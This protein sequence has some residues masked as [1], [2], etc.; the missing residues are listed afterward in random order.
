MPVCQCCPNFVSPGI[1]RCENCATPVGKLAECP[2]CYREILKDVSK[3]RHCGYYISDDGR[4]ASEYK[5]SDRD[6]FYLNDEESADSDELEF[7][8][9]QDAQEDF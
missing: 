2:N 6:S 9:E 7:G 8:Y 3:C 5:F 4:E 1:E